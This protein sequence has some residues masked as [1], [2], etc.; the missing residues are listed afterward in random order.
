MGN[1]LTLA[2]QLKDGILTIFCEGSLVFSCA[3]QFKTELYP[4][5]TADIKEIV[6]DMQKVA[7][8]DSAGLGLVSQTLNQ[9]ATR[10]LA[11]R[12][13]NVPS[14]ILATFELTGLSERL[15][16]HKNKGR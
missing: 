16:R 12:V 3:I 8:I 1:K 4:W 15:A 6:L 11:F 13:E 7:Q 5:L 10:G 2:T 14:A 9:T